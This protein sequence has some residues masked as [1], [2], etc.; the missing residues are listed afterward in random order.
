[1]YVTLRTRYNFFIEDA[2]REG[3]RQVKERDGIP[4]AEQIRRAIDA[5]LEQKG[6]SKAA[7]RRAPTRRKA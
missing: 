4:E 6:V 3:L 5:W 1:M 2:Q 7:L